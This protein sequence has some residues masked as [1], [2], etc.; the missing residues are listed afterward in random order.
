MEKP[1][2]YQRCFR[3]ELRKFGLVEAIQVPREREIAKFYYGISVSRWKEPLDQL[4]VLLLVSRLARVLEDVGLTVFIAGR[5]AQ[6]N[7]R[8]GDA[9]RVSELSKKE[10]FLRAMDQLGIAG[11]A[12]LIRWWQFTIN[13]AMPVTTTDNLWYSPFYWEEVLRLKDLEGVVDFSRKGKSFREV[14][15]SFEPQL[16]ARIPDRLLDSIGDIDAPALYRLLEVAEA[17]YMEQC[18]AAIKVGPA[19][20]EEYDRYIK[21]FMGVIRLRQPLDFRS[22]PGRAKALTPY[23]GNEGEERIFL[24]DGKEALA[25]KVTKMAQRSA[26][27]PV[28]FDGFMNPFVR[29]AILAVEAAASADSA[30]LSFFSRRVN[31][32]ADVLDFFSKAGT[33]QLLRYAPVVSESLWG[34]LI[35]PLGQA[36]KATGTEGME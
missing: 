1:D 35:R 25:I 6:L 21:D 33:G 3:E 31:S 28:F 22:L 10:L 15:A 36:I 26:G 19:S 29:T 12:N 23:I 30:P 7:G 18:A 32:G 27:Q 34:Y 17:S 8:D 16:R 13:A 14:V 11:N 24:D 4:D 5:Y 2:E 20:E 9:L